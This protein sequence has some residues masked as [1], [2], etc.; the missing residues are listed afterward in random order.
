MTTPELI[1]ELRSRLTAREYL[2]NRGELDALCW[3]ITVEKIDRE[4]RNKIKE[5]N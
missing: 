1:A 5:L 3:E 2:K 4:A